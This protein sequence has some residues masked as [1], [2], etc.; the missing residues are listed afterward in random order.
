MIPL[1]DHDDSTIVAAAQQ[2]DRAALTAL[3]ER[4]RPWIYN[5]ALRM[6]GDPGSAEDA[7]QD[8][9]IKVM[10][11][12]GSFE[13]RSAFRTWLYRVAFHH[14]L[15]VK[16]GRFEMAVGGFESFAEGLRVTPN[17]E[18]GDDIPPPERELL[19]SEAKVACMTA[20]GQGGGRHPRDP[21]TTPSRIR[22]S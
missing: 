8:I 9:F 2:G 18:L 20:A 19:V 17:I 1:V 7:A 12:L 22:S 3:I 14:L 16:R 11:R 5:I 10:D 13:G 6:M 15:N 4:H 21:A